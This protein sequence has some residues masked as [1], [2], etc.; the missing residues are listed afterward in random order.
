M[1]TKTTKSINITVNPSYLDEHS[2]PEDHHYVWA[3]QI[4]INNLGKETV[5]LKNRY[6]KIIDSNGS[7]QEIKGRGVV[8]EQPV[9]NP[10]EKFEY[11]SGT[12]LSTPSGFM[13]GYY[14]METLNGKTFD[15]SIPLF[16]LDSPYASNKLN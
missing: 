5:Q 10:G 1:Y 6:W 14:E 15:A 4:T 16:S 12:P 2:E 13:E 9:I 11:T 3:Y 8:G 7:K